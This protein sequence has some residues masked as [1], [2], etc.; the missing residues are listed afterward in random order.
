MN[1]AQQETAS[2]FH[3]GEQQAQ[4]R[5]GVRDKLEKVGRKHIRDHLPD[6]HREFYATLPFVL[7]GTVD[8]Q[9]RPWASLVAGRP[10]FMSTP[11]ARCLE[12]ASQPLFGDPL[13]GT[14]KPGAEVG[15]LGIQ[16][17]TRRRNRLTGQVNSTGPETI[18]INVDHTFGNCPKYIQTRVVEV[19]P[20]IDTPQ[21]ERPTTASDRF[22]A[23]VR[24]L[25][26]RADTLFIATAYLEGPDTSARGAD[27]SHR[28][29]RP[30][31]VRVEDDRTFVFP[32]FSGNLHFN[33]VGNILSNP[34]AGF[35][36]VDFDS[37]DLVYMTGE[38]E[39]IWEGEEVEAFAGAERLIRFRAETVIRVEGS[40]P[41]RFDFGEY[42][43][44]L[45]RTGSWQE[46]PV[47]T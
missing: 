30:G 19:R 44:N 6:Q 31:F 8:E 10:G 15:L 9:G 3:P 42:S 32:D 39:V 27:V 41:L 36:F 34:K 4:E 46:S 7:L 14:L 47:A 24:A 29:G 16:P 23:Y 2:P 33:T 28:G 17:E 13:I 38:A 43:P 25:I 5:M 18:S 45:E 40:L 20:G 37:G 35:L 1:V 22:D 11:D 12:I 21:A 26:E